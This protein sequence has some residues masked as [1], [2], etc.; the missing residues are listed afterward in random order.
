[1]TRQE[2]RIAEAKAAT[3]RRIE[4]LRQEE[5]RLE[6]QQV[7]LDRRRRERRWA[8]VG[9]LVEAAGLLWE[10][11]TRLEKVLLWGRERLEAGPGAGEKD[12]QE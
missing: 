3:Q 5:R 10:T 7:A 11:D 9:K 1:M 6:R 12:G 2:Q 8:E 4:V